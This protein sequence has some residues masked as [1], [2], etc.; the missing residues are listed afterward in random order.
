MSGNLR[1]QRRPELVPWTPLLF[2]K[3]L[4]TLSS[5]KRSHWAHLHLSNWSDHSWSRTMMNRTL[6]NII[7]RWERGRIWEVPCALQRALLCYI[8]L[9]RMKLS[10]SMLRVNAPQQ[11][12]AT[13]ELSSRTVWSFLEVIA[14]ICP[15]TTLTSSILPTRHSRWLAKETIFEWFE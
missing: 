1:L 13:L 7:S 12:M 15:S 6:I 10:F 14:I 5:I 8:V 11:E 3:R 4:K 2:C 9:V